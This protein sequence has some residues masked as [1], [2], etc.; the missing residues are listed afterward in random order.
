MV[1]RSEGIATM[2]R[3]NRNQNGNIGPAPYHTHEEPPAAALP[4]P[5]SIRP[6]L[7]KPPPPSALVRRPTEIPI[8]QAQPVIRCPFCRAARVHSNGVSGAVRYYVCLVCCDLDEGRP[9][10]FKVQI[11]DPLAK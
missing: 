4:D 9:S 6:P 1:E 7:P 11:T 8:P 2:S 10:T 3:R 5:E